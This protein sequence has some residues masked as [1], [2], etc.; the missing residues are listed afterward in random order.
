MRDSTSGFVKPAPNAPAS[1]T[2]SVLQWMKS[3]IIKFPKGAI[4]IKQTQPPIK[5][6][7]EGFSLERETVYP[8]DNESDF[9]KS[10]T[11]SLLSAFINFRSSIKQSSRSLV[12]LKSDWAGHLSCTGEATGWP[13]WL[14]LNSF[15]T[16][17]PNEL[18]GSERNSKIWMSQLGSVRQRRIWCMR[19]VCLRNSLIC[20][21][22]MAELA[23]GGKIFRL[24]VAW[25]FLVFV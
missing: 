12:W 7:A 2:T 8:K 11:F 9:H 25:A 15:A 17:A 3:K 20:C 13:K 24:H 1:A 18:G 22:P 4:G 5:Y 14:R 23:R 16:S 19:G 10:R 6:L 21:C